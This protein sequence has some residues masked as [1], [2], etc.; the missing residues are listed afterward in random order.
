MYPL[1]YCEN[2]KKKRRVSN[3]RGYRKEIA[4]I[5]LKIK[6][7]SE[8]LSRVKKAIWIINRQIDK[9]CIDVISDTEL[10]EYDHLIDD[11]GSVPQN[12]NGT[13]H[14]DSTTNDDDDCIMIGADN[15]TTQANAITV[16]VDA[17]ELLIDRGFSSDYTYTI[18]VRQINRIYE[19]VL[20]IIHIN[21]CRKGT[22]D[23]IFIATSRYELRQLIL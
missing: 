9:R 3:P 7:K 12:S 1:N 22:T 11:N 4:D 6:V 14:S 16:G 15:Q 19:S 17:T 10:E 5:K 23:I 8:R 18:D 21:L 2:P 20:V 13:S